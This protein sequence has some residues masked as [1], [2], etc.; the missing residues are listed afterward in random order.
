MRLSERLL[1]L[2]VLFL[3]GLRRSGQFMGIMRS[4]VVWE[5]GYSI[6]GVAL[7]VCK[8]HAAVA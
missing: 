4:C 7:S 3:F 2:G 6:R 5:N 8:L 1:D